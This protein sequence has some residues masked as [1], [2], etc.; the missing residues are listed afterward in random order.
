MLSGGLT[1]E[2]LAA[3]VRISG[4]RTIDVSSGVEDRPGLKNP[5][6]IAAFLAAARR[7][8]DDR[9]MLA[10]DLVLLERQARQW[11]HATW[12]RR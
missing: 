6:K 1:S 11:Y 9:L 4:A 7:L 5:A 12:N 2:N 10:E 3:A 8:I